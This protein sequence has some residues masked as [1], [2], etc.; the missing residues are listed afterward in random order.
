ML[1]VLLSSHLAISQICSLCI[2]G[3]RVMCY[4][5]RVMMKMGDDYCVGS[6]LRWVVS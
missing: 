3:D 2:A 4:V 1:A 5:F 6:E